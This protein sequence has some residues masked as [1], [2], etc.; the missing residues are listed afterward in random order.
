MDE[1]CVLLELGRE[2]FCL[3][4][5]LVE[6]IEQCRPLISLP[7]VGD[8]TTGIRIEGRQIAVGFDLARWLNC[9]GEPQAETYQ[10]LC[11]LRD[12]LLCL[13]VSQVAAIVPQ[14][15]GDWAPA[16]D[17]QLAR[18]CERVFVYRKLRYPLLNIEMMVRLLESN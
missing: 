18:G 4:E 13:P 7:R 5:P 10:L 3:Q 15:H 6:K 14:A 11:S 12:M 2:R 9:S 16:D 17:E 8:W 1:R